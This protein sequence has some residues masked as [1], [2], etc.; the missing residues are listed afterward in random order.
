MVTTAAVTHRHP[1]LT[2]HVQLALSQAILTGDPRPTIFFEDR[3][4]ELRECVAVA[5]VSLPE[6]REQAEMLAGEFMASATISCFPALIDCEGQ[7]IQTIVVVTH[8]FIADEADFAFCIA[9][10]SETT[11]FVEVTVLDEEG[12]YEVASQ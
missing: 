10:K 4:G 2:R 9:T 12:L 3:E 11:G 5:P 6:I 1:E 8:D 7:Q